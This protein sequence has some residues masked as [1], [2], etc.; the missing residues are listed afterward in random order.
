VLRREEDECMDG[1]LKR[2]KEENDWMEEG[3]GLVEVGRG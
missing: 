2:R 3:R 1:K